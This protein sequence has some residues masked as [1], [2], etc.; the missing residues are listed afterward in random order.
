MCE[1]RGLESWESSL[2]EM[3][4]KRRALTV[5][6]EIMRGQQRGEQNR[7]LTGKLRA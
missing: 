4:S 1:D 5:T 7:D 6:R 3:K 2:E